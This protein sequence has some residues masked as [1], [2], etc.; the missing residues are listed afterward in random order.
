MS[1]RRLGALLLV[2]PA[3]IRLSWLPVLAVVE[4]QAGLT[5]DLATELTTFGVCNAQPCSAVRTLSFGRVAARHTQGILQA[6]HL[7]HSNS[8]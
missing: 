8:S 4:R 2:R 1:S 6:S 5:K 3:L 7:N